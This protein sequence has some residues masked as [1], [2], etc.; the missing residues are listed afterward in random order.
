MFEKLK[1]DERTGEYFLKVV[2]D[3][4]CRAKKLETDFLRYMT[5]ALSVMKPL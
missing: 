4:S 3:F 2:E 5:P 1:L